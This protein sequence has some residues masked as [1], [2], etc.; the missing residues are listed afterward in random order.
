MAAA[1][2]EM[3]TTAQVGINTNGYD[4]GSIAQPTPSARGYAGDEKDPVRE[5]KTKAKRQARRDALKEANEKVQ[6]PPSDKIEESKTGAGVRGLPKEKDAVRDAAMREK[7]KAKRETE[8]KEQEKAGAG[9]DPDAEVAKQMSAIIQQHMDKI[10]PVCHN[11]R[12]SI[13]KADQR[14]KDYLSEQKLIADVKPLIHDSNRIL[15]EC[16]GAIRGLDPDGSIAKR[17]KERSKQGIASPEER[18][19]ATHLTDLTTT[20]VKTVDDGKKRLAD[21][22]EAEK[23]ISPLWAL[24]TEPMFMIISSVGLLVV[25]VLGLVGQLL[26]LFGLGGLVNGV[27]GGLGVANLMKG[28][29]LGSIAEALGVSTGDEKKKK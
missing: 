3:P 4:G 24:M 23:E 12:G 13:D 17:A 20:V 9:K 19:L 5:A 28:L 7:R 1:A 11:I 14:P 25:G 10:H 6:A 29:G 8:A 16:N 18:L 27:L 21:H 15:T 26:S 22:P 2:T